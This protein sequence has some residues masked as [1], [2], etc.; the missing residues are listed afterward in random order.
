[1]SDTLD[2]KGMEQ[3]GQGLKVGGGL[4]REPGRP[5]RESRPPT[6]STET[7]ADLRAD[8]KRLSALLRSAP[9]DLKAARD[10]HDSL[11]KFDEGL[12]RMSQLLKVE[13]IATMREGF[14]GL[15][16]SLS[17][18]AAQ[19]ERLSGY[20][21]P[22]VTFNGLKP[23]VEQRAFW[24]EGDKIAEGMRKAAKG[25]TAASEEMELLSEGPAETAPVARREP[26][27]RR[28]DARCPGPGAEAAGQGRGAFEERARTCRAPGGRAA[29][30]GGVTVEDPARDGQAQGGRQPAAA[31]AEGSRGRHAALAG[32][33]QEPRPLLGPAAQHA[34]AASSTS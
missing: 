33:A 9:P 23:S 21:Y 24:P 25:A 15:E 6:T 26:Q 10:I 34:G 8:A 22:V 13:R 14:K 19:V 18:G 28:H 7:S 12:E 16:E 32:A 2:P 27:G 4:S 20:S 1:V 3:F 11:V 29:A 30:P 17:T 5:R 31:D